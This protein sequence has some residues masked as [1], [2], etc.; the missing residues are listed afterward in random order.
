MSDGRGSTSI[1]AWKGY[2][3]DNPLPPST[4]VAEPGPHSPAHAGALTYEP[5]YGLKTKP[6]S[7]STDPR[8]LYSAPGHAQALDDLLNAIRRREGIIALTGEMGTGK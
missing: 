5:H 2:G 4:G 8:A 7:L 6:F 3:P 1:G